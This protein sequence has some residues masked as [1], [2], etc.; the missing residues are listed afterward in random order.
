[1][2]QNNRQRISCTANDCTHNSTQD[3]TCK[4]DKIAVRPCSSHQ[5]QDA[6]E[7]TACLSYEYSN[8]QHNERY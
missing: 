8:V 1:M 2:N 6:K 7:S 3:C 5:T 4:L